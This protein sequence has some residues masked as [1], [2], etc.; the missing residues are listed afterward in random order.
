MSMLEAHHVA[1]SNTLTTLSLLDSTHLDNIQC[2][3]NVRLG[4]TDLDAG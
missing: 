4:T 1:M 2:S 3:I